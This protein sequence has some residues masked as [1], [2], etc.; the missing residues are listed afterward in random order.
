[1]TNENKY[2]A[3]TIYWPITVA[4]FLF[5]IM[6]GTFLNNNI[7]EVTQDVTAIKVDVAEMKKDISWIV[8]YMK[9]GNII[10]AAGEFVPEEPYVFVPEPTVYD[11]A[12]VPV[13]KE[14][15][16]PKVKP[17]H[18]DEAVL[19]VLEELGIPTTTVSQ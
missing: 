2:V 3:F 16:V 12:I 15:V 5:I 9:E 18:P 4:T 19:K 10:G 17:I 7:N 14:P 1:M 11:P 6:V 13:Y 8:D